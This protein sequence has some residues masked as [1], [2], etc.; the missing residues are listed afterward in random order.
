MRAKVL[1]VS[2][3]NAKSR[4]A[5]RVLVPA[6]MALALFPGGVR[7]QT[8]GSVTGRVVSADRSTALA[9]VV[10]TVVGTGLRAETGVD[11]TFRFGSLVPG[12]YRL[13]LVQSGFDPLEKDIEVAEGEAAAVVVRLRPR[14]VA[15]D[16]IEVTGRIRQLTR[17]VDLVSIPGL[18]ASSLS[19]LL[20]GQSAGVSVTSTSGQAGAAHQI[21]IRGPRSLS[22]GRP[23]IFVDGVRVGSAN[24]PAPMGTSQILDFLDGINPADVQAIEVLRG[25]DAITFY[26]ME[27]RDGVI[28]ITTRRGGGRPLP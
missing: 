1:P 27:A 14:P 16:P 23:L 6:V 13:R 19:Q 5:S 15:L 9:G 20:K 28:R 22:P 10:V 18:D 7:T 3:L 24:L 2:F 8:P 12:V 17:R 11:G 26:G 21:R 25:P 4:W